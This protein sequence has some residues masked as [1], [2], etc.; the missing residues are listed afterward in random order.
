MPSR[1]KPPPETDFEEKFI[2][3]GTGHGGQKINKTNS[4]VQLTHK[5]TGIV[6]T[7]QATRSREQN[8]KIARE[9]LAEKLDVMANGVLSRKGIVSAAKQ[10]KANR[11]ERKRRKK[12]KDL[13]KEKEV[14]QTATLQVLDDTVVIQ[15]D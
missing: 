7:C 5:A 6:I 10:A 14:P 4:K 13:A 11:S 2:K 15:E 8:R 3:G 12:Y 1:P 9:L